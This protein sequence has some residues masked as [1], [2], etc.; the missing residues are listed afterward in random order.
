MW[1]QEFLEC[2][3]L[4][5]KT[6]MILPTSRPMR[7]FTQNSKTLKTIH[8]RLQTN[9]KSTTLQ[10]VVST[11]TT[12][13]RNFATPTITLNTTLTISMIIAMNS[14]GASE[15]TTQTLASHCPPPD[16]PSL[17]LCRSSRP[18]IGCQ[19]TF[20]GL[21]LAFGWCHGAH[22]SSWATTTTPIAM[23][24]AAGS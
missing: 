7:I 13:Y 15:S 21:L 18:S 24:W 1:L 20:S 2:R 4:A 19:C 3:T 23:L 11:P 6:R 17:K 10:K 9:T 22:A 14:T 12:S 8:Q 16:G 5:H